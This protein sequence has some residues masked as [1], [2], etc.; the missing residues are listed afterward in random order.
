[1]SMPEIDAIE[2]DDISP[3]LDETTRRVSAADLARAFD[4]ADN[5]C[6]RVDCM[7]HIDSALA[8][9]GPELLAGA[10]FWRLPY[11]SP[12]PVKAVTE[13]SLAAALEALDDRDGG[14]GID[15]ALRHEDGYR[16]LGAEVFAKLPG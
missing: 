1:M 7:T 5:S 14:S 4:F 8:Q 2:S 11:E 3:Y 6:G 12:D 13:E 16:R 10:V 9:G 15:E